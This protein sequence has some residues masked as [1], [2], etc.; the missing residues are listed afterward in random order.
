MAT[1]SI[2]LTEWHAFQRELKRVTQDGV[3]GILRAGANRAGAKFDG[4]VRSELPP[5]PRPL[6][7]AQHWTAKQ[8][9]WW[10]GTMHAKA[11]GRSKAL[12][13]WRAVYKKVRVPGTKRVRKVLVIS[14]SY[15]RTGTMVRS[16]T[17]DVVQTADATEVRYG[18]NT[19]YA[20]WVIDEVN[21]AQYH[22]GNWKTLQQF[23]A[24]NE[25]PVRAAFAEG[26]FEEID[27]LIGGP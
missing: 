20:K 17:Y 9:A 22:K 25:E 12:P 8:R 1:A 16:L 5:T 2:D 14:G 27:R 23:A 15:R 7:Q 6:H 4:I 13:G 11:Q 24:E 3:P 10:W 26:A 21:Q 18:T 19:L